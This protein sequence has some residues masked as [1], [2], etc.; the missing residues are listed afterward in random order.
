MTLQPNP[1][2]SSSS[3]TKSQEASREV[4]SNPL[5]YL[6]MI[7]YIKDGVTPCDHIKTQASSRMDILVQDVDLIKNEKP[8]WLTGV[9]TVVLLPSRTIITGTKA[10]HAVTDLCNISLDGVNG[11]HAGLSGM[12]AST[13]TLGDGDGAS[14]G[15]DSLFTCQEDKAP[16]QVLHAAPDTLRGAQDPRYEDKP[17]EKMN[18]TSLEEIMRRRGDRA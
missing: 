2:V 3:T 13:A 16:E 17:R 10:M 5:D 8:S 4:S 12:S 1:S 9:P 18:D 6:S 7:V 15:F 14:R 11:F